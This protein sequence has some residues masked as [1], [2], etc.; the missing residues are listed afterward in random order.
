MIV[1]EKTM[2][3]MEAAYKLKNQKLAEKLE[4]IFTKKI[5]EAVLDTKKSQR[6]RQKAISIF[7]A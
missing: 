3:E 7:Y 4:M 2:V 5:E 6:V 1:T